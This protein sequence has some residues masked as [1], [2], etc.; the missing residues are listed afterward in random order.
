MGRR[1]ENFKRKRIRRIFT[2]ERD[3]LGKQNRK[4]M[5]IYI[6]IAQMTENWRKIIK[7]MKCKFTV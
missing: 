3:I 7:K 1:P 2:V 4:K 5:E 6:K